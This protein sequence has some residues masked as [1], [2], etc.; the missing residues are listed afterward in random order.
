[1]RSY[2]TLD[3]SRIFVHDGSTKTPSYV[4][5]LVSELWESA[6]SYVARREAAQKTTVPSRY[7]EALLGAV[8][9]LST[10]QYACGGGTSPPPPPPP[11][12]PTNN[13]PVVNSVTP[14]KTNPQVGENIT[15]SW[16]FSDPDNN[17][18]VCDI[19]KDNNGSFD[20]TKSPCSR[21]DS[22]NGVNYS[23]P[24][25][26]TINFRVRDNNGGTA[27]KTAGPI[28]VNNPPP[29]TMT[30]KL[31][32]KNALA[33]GTCTPDMNNLPAGSVVFTHVQS[34]TPFNGVSDGQCGYVSPQIPIPTD[35]NFRVTLTDGS[36]QIYNFEDTINTLTS[37]TMDVWNFGRRTRVC[38][39]PEDQDFLKFFQRMTITDGSVPD[40]SGNP[41]NYTR[42]WNSIILPNNTIIQ[43]PPIQYFTENPDQRFLGITN[44]ARDEINS[45]F[46]N[47]LTTVQADP[48]DGGIKLT[49]GAFPQNFTFFNS[50][51]LDSNGNTISPKH[52]TIQ[53][54]NDDQSLTD[55]QEIM[56]TK[57]E[58]THAILAT[59]AHS[60]CSTD[61]TSTDPTTPRT[62]SQFES[63]L[64]RAYYAMPNGTKIKLKQ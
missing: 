9:M 55:Q 25:N 54:K 63:D 53:K 61:L 34:N 49:Y 13:I 30:L 47:M 58:L 41:I 23:V 35:G 5:K 43:I 44:T 60:T 7:S 12:P 18:F 16:D 28:S 50:F 52:V 56:Q 37:M 46:P 14:S 57:H 27:S 1:M 31:Q 21:T 6:K 33:N 45:L 51:I 24:G 32:L 40:N 19:D 48:V 59:G 11:P 15:V 26:Y 42:R 3:A 20:Y 62:Y 29:Q 10:L 64:I 36:N 39:S 38:G 17:T 2:E 8:L 4:S 22:F